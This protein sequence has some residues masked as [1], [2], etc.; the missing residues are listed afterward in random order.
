MNYGETQIVDGVRV[1]YINGPHHIP[2]DFSAGDLL[3]AY[4]YPG[5]WALYPGHDDDRNR[6]QPFDVKWHIVLAENAGVDGASTEAMWRDAEHAD[7]DMLRNRRGDLPPDAAA[8]GEGTLSRR[9]ALCF[10]HAPAE[11][12]Q[13]RFADFDVSTIEVHG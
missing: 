3:L 6:V 5:Y 7:E 8:M 4:E 2:A 10:D 9:A 13:P 1:T 12:A 11:F